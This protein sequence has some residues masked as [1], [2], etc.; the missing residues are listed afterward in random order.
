MLTLV[1]HGTDD[2]FFPYGN[3]QAVAREIPG[4]PLARRPGSATPGQ[5]TTV[6][7]NRPPPTDSSN[8]TR[9]IIRL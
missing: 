4:G 1:V 5:V 6:K 8:R 2:P 7:R 9:S 3:G